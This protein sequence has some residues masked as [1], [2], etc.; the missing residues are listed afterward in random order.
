MGQIIFMT[1]IDRRHAMMAECAARL[2]AAGTLSGAACFHLDEP[3]WGARWEAR[4]STA[5]V[6]LIKWMGTT[7]RTPFFDACRRFLERRG[8]PYYIDADGSAEKEAAF[9]FPDEAKDRLT[10]Y[11]MANGRKNYENIF[12]YLAARFQG[13]NVPWEEPAEL[14]WAGL[15]HPSLGAE[16]MTDAA[17]YRARFCRP[18]R[19]T[20]ALLFYRDEWIWGDLFYQRAFAEEAERQGMNAVLL[21]TNGLP[22]EE[23]GMPPLRRVFREFLTDG[24]R[25][26]VD[27][28]V[29]VLKFSFTSSGS[30]GISEMKELGIPV[31]QGYTTLAPYEEWRASPFGLSDMETSISVAMPE[32]D[33]II[34]GVPVASKRVT[35]TGNVEYHPILGRMRRMVSKARK[36]ALL[37]RKENAEKRIAVIFHNYPPKDSNIGSALGL[38]TIES[39]RRLLSRMKDAGYDIPEVPANGEDLLR[40]LMRHATNDLERMTEAEAAAAMRV[41]AA[42][43]KD[44]FETLGPAARPQMEKDWGAAPGRVMRGDDGALL[45]PG[46]MMGSVFVTVQAPR[47]YGMDPAKLYH[48][49]FVAPTHQYEAFYHWIRDIWGADAV[50]HVGT[51]G[52]LEWLPGKGS[53]LDRDAYPDSALGDLPNVY[54]YHMTIT[55][56][57]IQ[58]KRRGA[59]CLIEHLPAPQTDAGL[60]DE[61]DE[62]DRVLSDYLHFKDNDPAAA[63]AL[64]PMIRERAKKAEMDGEVPYDG[65]DF[66]DYA[67]RLA[68]YLE[69]LKDSE[70]HIGLHIL[71]EPPKDAF[72][73][74]T[75]L[76]LLRL[77]NGDHPSI[78]EL[79][80]EKWGTSLKEISRRAGERHPSG[81]LYADIMRRIREETRD[82]IDTLRRG[83][84]TKDAEAAALA[85]PFISSAPAAWQ[86]QLCALLRWT[87]DEVYPALLRTT[88]EAENLLRAL[89]GRYIEPGPS[90]S[91]SAGGAALLPT[92]RNFYGVDPRSLPT[93]A[94][95]EIGK[96]LADEVITRFIAE[97][98]RYPENIGMVFWAGAN[99]RSRG[100]CI[101]EFLYLMGIRP[102][103]QA[104]SLR[105]TDLEVI[106]LAELRRPRID[107]TARISGLFRDTMPAVASLMDRAV[108]LAAS[109]N[110]ADED[111]FIRRHIEEDS[112]ELAASGMEKEEAYRAAAFRIFGDA[113]GTYGA[114]VGAVLEEKNWETVD[115]LARVYV[116][117]GAHAYGGAVKG[118]YMPERFEKRLA[119]MDI[120]VKNEDDHDTNMLASDDYNAYHGGMIASVRSLRGR[121][122]R[123]YCGDAT[124]RSRP[125]LRSI[126]EEAKR[127][128]RSES[129]N[130]KYIEGMMQHGYKGAADLANMVAHSYQWDATSGIMDDWMYEKYAEKYAFDPRVGEWMRRVNPHALRR[131]AETL[132]EAEK[133][134]L[135]HAKEE[136]KAELEKLYLDIEGE[137]EEATDE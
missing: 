102:V 137:I 45:V 82:M 17:A 107:V 116:R 129:I 68:A 58:A 39:V 92:G 10:R 80:A 69:E 122:P 19:P 16:C 44:F 71:G 131:I 67:L 121:A 78:L 15:W 12:L 95:W 70:V 7:I 91:P 74:E 115:D 99:M 25:P 105:V 76:S 77:A 38:D 6:V 34:H 37:R 43:Y 120:T 130:P 110:E 81:L 28:L 8:I 89:E 83:H 30:V 135:W 5:A 113:P 13:K 123:S 103:W 86:E 22:Q 96:I 56:E 128:F 41:P 132:L 101:A 18:G 65:G 75:L 47:G 14:P 29:S 133:R 97:E 42:D 35:D 119:V 98:G 124:D 90:G 136:T 31:L 9:H 84:F 126:S 33:G 94:A 60:Y 59:A 55:G 106:P 114:G 63:A 93:P 108:L 2:S 64:I 127:I 51:H 21:F 54:P 24:G 26:F 73:T 66:T 87:A 118:T 11:M 117:W 112:E 88:D 52:N 48:D 57:G 134:G 23:L 53:G 46:T 79:F 100:Q 20:A 32:L 111:N 62:L 109:R 4:L 27:V 104:G 85:L 125:V 61:T 50:I 36:W 3:V 49:P 72:M 1:N 40:E